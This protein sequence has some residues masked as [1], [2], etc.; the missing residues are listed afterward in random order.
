MANA[1]LTTRQLAALGFQRHAGSEPPRYFGRL[2]AGSITVPVEL[3]IPDSRLVRL[4]VVRIDPEFSDR[5]R[6]R[7]H[8]TEGNA[9]CYTDEN[10][11]VLDQ[12][13]LMASIRTVLALCETTLRELL[14]GNAEPS[15]RAE[16][17]AY[18]KG[19]CYY[20]I[21]DLRGSDR[22]V[23]GFLELSAGKGISVIAATEETI[24][25]WVRSLGVN[26]TIQ[27]RM[28]VAVI[29]RDIP[30]PP[31]LPTLA[32]ASAWLGELLGGKKDWLFS[33][34]VDGE[35]P[36]AVIVANNGIIGFT[37]QEN[38]VIKQAQKGQGFRKS[39]LG[40]LWQSQAGDV[41]IDKFYGRVS[42]HLEMVSRNTDSGPPLEEKKICL[43]GCGTIGGYLAR[44]LVQSGAGT[45]S[46]LTLV[47]DQ[48]FLPENAGRHLLGFSSVGTM[49]SVATANALLRDFPGV[50]IEPLTKPAQEL[51]GQFRN[52]DLVIDATGMER[53]SSALNLFAKEMRAS[54]RYPPVIYSVIFGNGAAV[55]SFLDRGGPDD[56][57][58]QCLR[59]EYGKPWRFNSL[60]ATS[61]QPA[62]AVRPC[63]VGSYVPYGVQASVSAATLTLRQV[64]DFFAGDTSAT[65]RTQAI[66]HILAREIPNKSVA[67]SPHCPACS[68]VRQ[69]VVTI[70]G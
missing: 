5:H 57:C 49:K 36:T 27:K 29:E 6:L 30:S 45:N 44:M 33:N 25:S 35:R 28:S 22:A 12:F 18:W 64:L 65:L 13:Q 48:V 31:A 61:S 42:T 50:S 8:L 26:H 39:T 16:I 2:K 67:R 59:P 10:I 60:K 37:A 19:D 7:G 38:A 11:L 20:V 70:G 66:D 54:D 14:H 56:A 62:Y 40:Q 32:A 4:P 52:Y 51:W 46:T 24:A 53:F 58:Y 21:D 69:T 43:I 9:L 34:T 68:S 1:A 47:D 23:T 17:T 3:E 41:G 63:S 15:I 55:Q